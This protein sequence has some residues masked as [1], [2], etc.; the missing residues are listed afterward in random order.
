MKIIP[1]MLFISTSIQSTTAIES[2]TE[3]Q[4]QETLSAQKVIEIKRYSVQEFIN[5][6]CDLDALD[7]KSGRFYIVKM[8][9]KSFLYGTNSGLNELELC[10]EI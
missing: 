3:E 6:Q 2:I 4:V 1:I 7:S 8:N 10:R 9:S 5:N